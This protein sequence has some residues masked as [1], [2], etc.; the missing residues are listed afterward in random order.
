MPALHPSARRSAHL[1]ARTVKTILKVSSIM[2][3]SAAFGV[4]HQAPSRFPPPQNLASHPKQAIA[5]LV[6]Q[7]IPT[8]SAKPLP[9]HTKKC[10]QEPNEESTPGIY[11][12]WCPHLTTALLSWLLDHPADHTILFNENKGSESQGGTAKPHAQRK[13]DIKAIIAKV[14]FEKDEK[15][16]DTYAQQPAKFVTAV[17]NCLTR[18]V[19]GTPSSL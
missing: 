11:W 12:E 16:G 9:K 7:P 5:P 14:I 6:A 18:Q 3:P 15:Y 8:P 19:F 10:A 4:N 13:Q 17:G 2:I 1:E